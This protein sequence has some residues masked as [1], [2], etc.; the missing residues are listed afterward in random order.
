[1]KTPLLI[2]AVLLLAAAPVLAKSPVADK[3][4]LSGVEHALS[5]DTSLVGHQ[6]TATVKDGVVTLHGQAA[7]LAQRTSAVAE[8]EKIRGVVGVIDRMVLRSTKLSDDQIAEAIALRIEN[9]EFTP[10]KDLS[11]ECKKGVVTL[12]GGCADFAET[13]IIKDLAEDVAGVTAIVDKLLVD[14]GTYQGDLEIQNEVKEMFDRSALLHHLPIKVQVV[15]G[16]VTLS[17]TVGSAYEKRR[18]AESVYYVSHVNGVQN[19]MQVDPTA[20]FMPESGKPVSDAELRQ[21]VL[22]ELKQDRRVAAM[23]IEVTVESGEV[24]LNGTVNVDWQKQ[25]AQRDAQDVVGARAVTDALKVDPRFQT[26]DT[27]EEIATVELGS[28]VQLHDQEIRASVKNSVITISGV[29]NTFPQYKRATEVVQRI[30]GVR[31]V[32]NNLEIEPRDRVADNEIAEGIRKWL[33][34]NYATAPVAPLVQVSVENGFVTLQGEVA[35][36]WQKEV[37][38][39]IADYATGVRRVDNRIRVASAS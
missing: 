34:W 11:V 37:I 39:H 13:H 23:P 24:I 2:T 30:M 22:R 21:N 5:Q 17:G 29:V 25:I 3:D 8:A 15:D 16:V 38:Q 31:T 6:I 26:D 27:L 14:G 12:R 19:D 18:A 33:E 7:D 9:S 20:D 32:L 35:Y 36:H 10:P 28:D 1:M 4:I